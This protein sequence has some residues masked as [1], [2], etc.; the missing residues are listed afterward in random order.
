MSSLLFQLPEELICSLY[1]DMTEGNIIIIKISQAAAIAI[2]IIF[3]RLKPLLP[4]W[5][6]YEN[7]NVYIW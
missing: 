1:V 2:F 7:P 6:S 5:T 4:L 3:R